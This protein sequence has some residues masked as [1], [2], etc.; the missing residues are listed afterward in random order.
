MKSQA[1]TIIAA[2]LLF[3]APAAANDQ[4]VA[5]LK[6]TGKAVDNMSA[7]ISQAKTD[8]E[9]QMVANA[10]RQ[11]L[12]NGLKQDRPMITIEATVGRCRVTIET[13][14]WKLWSEAHAGKITDHGAR[15]R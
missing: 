14:A 9:A 3:T 10:V 13:P 1:A 11:A 7:A 6:Q 2:A 8:A 15:V 12:D 5:G 4:L